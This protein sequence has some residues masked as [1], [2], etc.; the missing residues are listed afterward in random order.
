MKIAGT[1]Y[2]WMWLGV[3]ALAV[4][5]AGCA[6]M[7]TNSG[8][9]TGQTATNQVSAPSGPQPLYYDFGDVLIPAELSFQKSLSFVMQTPGMSAGVLSFKGRVE[10]GSLISFF[11]NSMAKDNWQ[12]VS[13]FKSPRT[14]MVFKKENRLCVINITDGSYTTTVEIW[15]APTMAETMPSLS[16]MKPSALD[17][18]E[19]MEMTPAQNPGAGQVEESGL[20]K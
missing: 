11:Q 3:I 4:L 7:K 9:T 19:S 16:Q 14:M 2:R 20:L 12:P 13:L 17:S 8:K 1:G 18:M 6:G 5:A 10:Q 15:V